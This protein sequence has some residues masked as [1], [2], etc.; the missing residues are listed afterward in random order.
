MTIILITALL[1]TLISF[2]LYKEIRKYSLFIYG[3]F[4]V[5]SFF[6]GEES[7]IISLGYVPFGI[8]LVVMYSGVLEKGLL[9][10]RLF[11]VRKELAIIASIL[12]LPHGLGYLE[13]YLEDIG[14]FNG[15]VS[16]YI[17]IISILVM[18]P[19]TITSFGYIRKKFTY[20]SWK[21]VHLLAY[22]FYLLVGL[23][24]ILISNDRQMMYIII[25]GVYFIL[26]LIMIIQK[27]I[28]TNQKKESL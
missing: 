28:D 15:D 20:K 11:M 7:N 10:K 4:I 2:F 22:P 18:I 1:C 16:F 26:K 14:I 24:L 8:F 27:Y 9:R 12:V 21:K 5:A 13:Y 3:V 23:H 6:I 17:G 25:F 19:L